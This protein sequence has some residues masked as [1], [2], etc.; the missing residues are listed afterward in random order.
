METLSDT[1][2]ALLERSKRFGPLYGDRLANHLPMTLIALDRMGAPVDSMARAFDA[3]AR[4]LQAR[5]ADTSPVSEPADWLGKGR[6]AGG[7]ERYFE[8]CAS[9]N[10]LDAVLR[11]WLPRLLPGVAAS[12]FHCLIRLAYAIDAGDRDEACAALAYWVMEYVTLDLP[13]DTADD[14]PAAIAAPVHRNS[15]VPPV[16]ASTTIPSGPVGAKARSNS[17]PVT[18]GGTTNGRWIAPSSS[19][20]PG[21]SRRA[22][23][24]ASA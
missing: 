11:D 13:P 21:K 4:Q 18:T 1:C 15:T 22:S 14:T 24:Q 5:D 23:S 3:N 9:R 17:Q 2:R 8:A 6:N 19:N 7:L 20:F 12:A 16:I 10:G